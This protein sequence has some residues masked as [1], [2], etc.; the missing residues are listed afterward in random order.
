MGRLGDPDVDAVAADTG[1]P[2]V[3]GQPGDLA[4]KE[5]R[6]RFGARRHLCRS[7]RESTPP[8][9]GLRHIERFESSA[10]SDDRAKAAPRYTDALI[11]SPAHLV[12]NDVAEVRTRFSEAEVIELSLG[13]DAPRVEHGTER[14]LIGA[15]GKTVFS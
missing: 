14:Y 8:T 10:L 9:P 5:C 6:Q 2:H 1:L 11:W 13:A 12:A 3:V 4:C 7:A 15:D